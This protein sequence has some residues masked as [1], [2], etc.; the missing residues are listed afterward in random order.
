MV[1]MKEWL[2]RFTRCSADI[3]QERRVAVLPGCELSLWS[4]LWVCGRSRNGDE[5]TNGRDE[6]HLGN[7][8]VSS[9]CGRRDATSEEMSGACREGR[10]VGFIGTCS[11]RGQ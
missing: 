3:P 9:R 6:L 10:R 4:N 7:Q 1:M 2:G 5:A 11:S 8:L